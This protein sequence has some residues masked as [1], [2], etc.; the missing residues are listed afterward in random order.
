MAWYELDGMNVAVTGGNRGL[1]ESM[2]TALAEAGANV[3]ITGRDTARLQE[4]VASNDSRG[5]MTGRELDVRDSAAVEAFAEDIWEGVGPIDLLINNAGIANTGPATEVSDE[6]WNSIIETNLTGTFWCCRSFGKRMLERG[7]GHIINLASDIGITGTPGWAPYGSS[8]GAL[9]TLTKT[10][11]W[12]WAP[13]VRVNA[14][15]PGAFV[16][17]INA[18]IRELPGVFEMVEGEIPLGR[19]GSPEEIGPLAVYM[20]SSASAYMT[21]TVVSLDGGLKRS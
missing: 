20:A 5:T 9:I 17:D 12:E 19:W 10:L 21:G 15:A 4:T 16:T 7:S 14:I 18:G 6:T 11:A 2:A 8:K 1:G 13:T 3:V